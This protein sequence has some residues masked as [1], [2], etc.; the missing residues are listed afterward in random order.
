[1]TAVYRG[2]TVIQK[3]DQYAMIPYDFADVRGRE[4]GLKTHTH[5]VKGEGDKN[6]KNLRASYPSDFKRRP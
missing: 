6:G 5:T 3:N 2:F 4:E 1:M